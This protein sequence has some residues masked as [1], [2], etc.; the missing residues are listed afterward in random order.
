LHRVANGV[1]GSATALAVI[2][3]G[4]SNVFACLTGHRR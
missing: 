1:V 2:P 3:A 4:T